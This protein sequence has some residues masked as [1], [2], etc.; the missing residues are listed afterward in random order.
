MRTLRRGQSAECEG[1]MR[2]SL[3]SRWVTLDGCDVEMMSRR[4]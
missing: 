3:P 2:A 1:I 4:V